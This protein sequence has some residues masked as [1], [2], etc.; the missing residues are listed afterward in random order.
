MPYSNIHELFDKTSHGLLVFDHNFRF[1]D[2]N[3]RGV[4]L[5]PEYTT[6]EAARGQNIADLGPG[7]DCKQ[8]LQTCKKVMETGKAYMTQSLCGEPFG[9]KQLVIRVQKLSADSFAMIVK[10]AP[11]A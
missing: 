9:D 8:R 2:A 3:K 11:R 7:F 5:L 6:L 10:E 4:S 1:V